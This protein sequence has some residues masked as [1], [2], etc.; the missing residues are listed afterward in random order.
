[1]ILLKS[2]SKRLKTSLNKISHKKAKFVWKSGNCKS[3][4]E[5]LQVAQEYLDDDITFDVCASLQ[6]ALDASST[7]DMILLSP[8]VHAMN[9]FRGIE[10]GGVVKGMFDSNITT[11]GLLSN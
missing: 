6:E 4:M 7:D 11:R 9:K 8:G 1:M 3:L 10:N 2:K 5:N